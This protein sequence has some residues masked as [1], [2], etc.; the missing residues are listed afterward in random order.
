M[1]FVLLSLYVPVALNCCVEPWLIVAD[2][3]V[4]AMEVRVGPEPEGP[5]EVEHAL[6]HAVRIAHPKRD[7]QPGRR[8]NETI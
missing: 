5:E 2:S 1:S 7:T 3:G 6:R 4:T 8:R